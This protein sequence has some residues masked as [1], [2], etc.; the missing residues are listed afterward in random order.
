MQIA[1]Q[2]FLCAGAGIL[3]R[4]HYTEHGEKGRERVGWLGAERD[5]KYGTR[6]DDRVNRSKIV[7]SLFD[8]LLPLHGSDKGCTLPL[9]LY[10]L[11]VVPL[12]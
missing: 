5:M 12:V 6:I 9:V 4:A 10:R 7:R 11:T 3:V 8:Q 1:V 2:R